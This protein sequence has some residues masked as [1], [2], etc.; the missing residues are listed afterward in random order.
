MFGSLLLCPYFK[1]RTKMKK[2]LIQKL[3]LCGLICALLVL[4]IIGSANTINREKSTRAVTEVKEPIPAKIVSTSVAKAEE[5]EEPAEEIPIV[6]RPIQ[7]EEPPAQPVEEEP[8]TP[9]ESFNN[10]AAYI[11]KTI[12]GEA[13]GLGATE[14]AA[15]AWCILNRVDAGKGNIISVVT[16]PRQ[17]HG[18][19]A[20]NPVTDDI[21]NLVLDVLQ[22]WQNEKAG[23]VDVGRVLPKE[24]LFFYGSGGHNHFTTEYQGGIKYDWGLASPYD[25]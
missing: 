24:Y 1:R 12:Y 22:R 11:A 4:A 25:N 8:I 10:E 19:S 21:Y 20:S 3:A 2:T 6:V 13:G 23:A 17:F 16:A 15:V 18:Y 5:K 7:N 14:Q 9:T